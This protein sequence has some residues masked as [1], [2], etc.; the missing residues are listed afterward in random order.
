MKNH[1]RLIAMAMAATMLAGSGLTVYAGGSSGGDTGEGKYEGYVDETSVFS[2]QVPT[3]AA[4]VFDFFVDPNGLLAE[5]GY[6]RLTG[7]TEADF[8]TDATLFFTRTVT[9]TVTKEFGKDSDSV[10]FTNM[11]SYEVDVQVSATVDGATGIT[12]S[13]SADVDDAEVPT[14]YLAI[15]SGGSTEAITSNGGTFTG[16][17]NGKKE[18][19]EIQWDGEKYVYAL[20]KDTTEAEPTEPWET[21]SFNLT[22]ACGGDWTAEQA[23]VAPVVTLTWKVTDPLAQEAPSIEKTTYAMTAGMPV[24]I[25][26]DLGAGELAATDVLKVAY[27][28]NGE[29]RK[30]D[31]TSFSY[32]NGVLTLSVAYIDSLLNGGVSSREH[33]ITFNDA[34]NTKV[35]FTL[36]TA[37]A[38]S[39]AT[40]TYTMTAKT[41]VNIPVD[42]GVGNLAATGISKITYEKSGSV[43]DLDATSYTYANGVLTLSATY[44]DSLLSGGVSSREHTIIFNDSAA[45]TVTITLQK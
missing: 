36:L 4:K 16:K 6:A 11:S 12:L 17:I 8:E 14:I 45:T 5:T 42:L 10:T 34:A 44:V 41:A 33:T 39:I 2:V 13:D 30:L 38:P 40:T 27:V 29:T 43:R 32:A 22:G 23:E 28:K 9:E 19:F 18:N 15:V 3:N 26:V 21:I 37:A 1:K 31:A 35:V 7:K 25:P 24:K 20:K